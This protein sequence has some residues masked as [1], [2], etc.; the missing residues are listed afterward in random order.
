MSKDISLK[1]LNLLPA[2]R[3]VYSK[4]GGH[5]VFGAVIFVLLVYVFLVIRINSLANA[6]P[7]ADQQVTVTNSVPRIDSKT[8]DQIQSLENNNTEV[9]SLFEQARNNPFAE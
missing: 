1:S 7:S 6:E 2:I 5:A 4:Y 9:H 3:K 8:I